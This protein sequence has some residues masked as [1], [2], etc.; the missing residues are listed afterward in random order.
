MQCGIDMS[1]SGPEAG[2]DDQAEFPVL[3]NSLSYETDPCLKNEIPF[4]SSPEEAKFIV[5][6][7]HV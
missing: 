5:D 4:Q 1:G 6:E 7:P 2:A 3:F